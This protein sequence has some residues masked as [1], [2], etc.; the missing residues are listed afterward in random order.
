MH[1]QLRHQDFFSFLFT[2]LKCL[3]KNLLNVEFMVFYEWFPIDEKEFSIKIIWNISHNHT[4]LK[5]LK[6]V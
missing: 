1:A 3:S 5:T 6:Y 4:S 2:I